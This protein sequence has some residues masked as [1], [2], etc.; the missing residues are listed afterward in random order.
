MTL[1][2][3]FMIY[4]ALYVLIPPCYPNHSELDRAVGLIW[5]VVFHAIGMGLLCSSFFQ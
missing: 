4:G 3:L 2:L 1:A 5:G